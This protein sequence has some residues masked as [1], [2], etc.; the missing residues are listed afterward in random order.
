MPGIKEIAIMAFVCLVVLK[1]Y[2]MV[3][4]VAAWVHE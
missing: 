3:P 1:Y 2:R 4:E